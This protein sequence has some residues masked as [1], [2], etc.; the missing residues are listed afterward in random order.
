MRR[1]GV[2]V[3]QPDRAAAQ[4]AR[5]VRDGLEVPLSD[6]QAVLLS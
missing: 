3:K 2:G 6:A 1:P 4:P 5:L